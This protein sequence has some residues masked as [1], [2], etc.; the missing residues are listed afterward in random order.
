MDGRS[1]YVNP[2]TK[3]LAWIAGIVASLLAL[4][5]GDSAPLW[6]PDS[7][8]YVGALI[9][10][11]IRYVL[12]AGPVTFVILYVVREIVHRRRSHPIQLDIIY[13]PYRALRR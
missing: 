13:S 4:K 3:A 8:G 9:A 11:R 12:M 1:D 6:L 7:W 10:R 5:Y 2:S